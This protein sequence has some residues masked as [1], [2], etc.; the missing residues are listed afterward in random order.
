MFSLISGVCSKQL[1]GELFAELLRR[2]VN[3]GY[4]S[5]GSSREVDIAMNQAGT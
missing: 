5:E 2:R 3:M 4:W 1:E